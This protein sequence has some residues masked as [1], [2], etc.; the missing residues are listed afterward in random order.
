MAD[1]LSLPVLT[2][3]R[4]PRPNT[5]RFQS[6]EVDGVI[7][8]GTRR[9]VIEAKSYGLGQVEVDEILLKYRQIVRDEMY[10]IAPS[11]EQQL[12]LPRHVHAICFLPDFSRIQNAYL[13][14]PYQL[15]EGLEH[16]LALGDHHFRY[17]SACRRK[18]DATNFRNQVDKKMK[19]VAQVLR[20]I[21]RQ[22]HPCDLPIRVFW[23]ISGWLFPKELFFSSYPN[24]LLRRG[25]A[26]DIDGSAIH[27]A[28]TPCK[29]LPG[30]T[31]CTTCL[32]VAKDATKQL[33]VFLAAQGFSR[34]QIVFSGR[35]GFHV[36]VL[37]QDLRESEVQKIVQ[38][39]KNAGIPI[40]IN[41]ALDRKAVLTFPGS[42]H[43]LTMLRAVPVDDLDAFTVHKAREQVTT[44]LRAAS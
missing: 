44:T 10:I 22:S 37:Q 1:V 4:E 17:A 5:N 12:A 33:L 18:R 14:P 39:V 8:D 35:Q 41:L 9:I 3:V 6:P 13:E 16:E 26:F 20:D 36:Y 11:F 19:T 2:N 7:E 28:S 40:D 34:L 29:L 43:G 27:N 38:A 30:S 15:P 32:T 21:R 25:L 31:T 23:S 42:I 24:Q